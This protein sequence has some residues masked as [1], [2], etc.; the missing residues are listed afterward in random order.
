M[1]SLRIWMK[2]LWYEIKRES[3]I[4]PCEVKGMHRIHQ[5]NRIMNRWWREIT[6]PLFSSVLWSITYRIV[7]YRRLCWH[8]ILYKLTKWIIFLH[9]CC[10]IWMK[11]YELLLQDKPIMRLKP[12][13]IF[14]QSGLIW[15]QHTV[16]QLNSSDWNKVFTGSSLQMKN[17]MKLGLSWHVGPPV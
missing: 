15:S 8:L 7:I 6:S 13:L 17:C 14:S 3:F 16:C 4:S 9:S 2:E 12:W 5:K 10:Q 11:C 1:R